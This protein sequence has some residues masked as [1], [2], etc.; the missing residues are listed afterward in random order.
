MQVIRYILYF[1]FTHPH[2]RTNERP[3]DF[4]NSTTATLLL[5]SSPVKCGRSSA[6]C[7]RFCSLHRPQHGEYPGCKSNLFSHPSS[8]CFPRVS[9]YAKITR[10]PRDPAK[11]RS[12]SGG[13]QKTA[14][15]PSRLWAVPGILHC[16]TAPLFWY[17]PH[18]SL[19]IMMLIVPAW[20]IVPHATHYDYDSLM[21]GFINDSM[22]EWELRREV[23]R[24]ALFRTVGRQD[25][26]I[27]KS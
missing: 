21:T 20:K 9:L 22:R 1:Q 27:F 15:T 2:A 4:S 3:T 6:V 13:S 23:H 12:V 26:S 7:P 16:A 25:T 24:N 14:E 19:M 8:S 10:V 17:L 18:H 5:F 11:C